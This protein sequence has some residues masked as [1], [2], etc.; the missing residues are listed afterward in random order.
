M[1]LGDWALLERLGA[2]KIPPRARCHLLATVAIFIRVTGVYGDFI[3]IGAPE[4]RAPDGDPNAG[5]IYA[6]R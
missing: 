1:F 6:Y 2:G 5:S 3:V 4:Y